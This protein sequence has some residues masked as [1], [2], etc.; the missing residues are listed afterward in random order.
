MINLPGIYKIICKNNNKFYIGSSNNIDKRLYHHTRLLNKNKHPNKYLQSAWNEYGEKNFRFEIIETI[1]NIKDLSIREKWWLDNTKCYKRKIGFNIYRYP[2]S[3][4]GNRKFVDLTGKRFGRLVVIKRIE[5]DKW[6]T[7]QYLCRCDCGN[8]TKVRGGHLRGKNIKSCGCLYKEGNYFKHGYTKTHIYYAW[9]DMLR[10]CNYKKHHAYK[11]YGG[12]GIK[13]CERWANKK[14]GFI[15]FLSDVGK[16]PEGMSI[17]RIDN[18]QGY[19]LKNHRWATNKQQQRNRRNSKLYCYNGKKQ[20]ITALA[21]EYNINIGTLRS[22]LSRGWSLK[23][24]L[25]TP[26]KRNIK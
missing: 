4:S 25:T 14:N 8:E 5:N 20:C 17:D 11:N 10:R 22:R 3:S 26:I 24:S 21:E 2:R 18:N 19:F 6:G 7:L 12:R 15:N 1:C 9:T 16:P 13:V 23:K